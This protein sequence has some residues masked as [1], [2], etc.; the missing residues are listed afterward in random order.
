MGYST[1]MEGIGFY[2]NVTP[3][4]CAEINKLVEEKGLQTLTKHFTDKLNEWKEIPLKIGIIGNSGAGKSTFINSLRGIKKRDKGAAKTGSNETTMEPKEFPHPNNEKITIWDLPG[5]GTPNFPKDEYLEKIGFNTYD[6]FVVISAARFTENDLFLTQRILEKNKTFYFVRN[7]IDQELE[8]PDDDDE[9]I[10]E[11]KVLAEIRNE[12]LKNLE[13]MRKNM[14]YERSFKKIYLISAMFKKKDEFDFPE[15][16][17]DLLVDLPKNKSEVLLRVISTTS[18]HIIK[19]KQKYLQS[20]VS[21]YAALTGFG[22]SA[23]GLIPVPMPGLPLL[24]D[25]PT[26]TKM[27]RDQRQVLGTT[28]ENIIEH[29]K[30]LGMFKT[31]DACRRDDSRRNIWCNALIHKYQYRWNEKY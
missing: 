10:D 29:A 14:K 17:K 3:E 9:T 26:I 12:T 15:L 7:K 31:F 8:N 18:E 20:R 19:E 22:G 4:D 11:V 5:V 13:D 27:I 1:K 16:L 23:V 6:C 21:W 30:N 25:A 28:D 24:V 2:A